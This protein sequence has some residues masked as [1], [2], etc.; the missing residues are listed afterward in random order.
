MSVASFQ[1]M[2][3]LQCNAYLNISGAKAKF[4]YTLQRGGINGKRYVVAKRWKLLLHKPVPWSDKYFEAI[5][6]TST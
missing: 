1:E 6:Q 2:P 3:P 4:V 5:W